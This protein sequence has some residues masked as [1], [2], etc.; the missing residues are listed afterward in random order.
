M[1]KEYMNIKS[2]EWND[3]TQN[4]KLTWKQT[5]HLNN[6]MKALVNK[7]QTFFLYIHL[8]R[9]ICKIGGYICPN[10][11]HIFYNKSKKIQI[12]ITSTHSVG[13]SLEEFDVEP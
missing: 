7:C 1:V 11:L 13:P 5:I 2:T 3:G 9:F 4:S 6:F 10:L 12:I 8:H